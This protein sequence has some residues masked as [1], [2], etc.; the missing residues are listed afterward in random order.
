MAAGI[1]VHLEGDKTREFPGADGAERVVDTLNRWS[2]SVGALAVLKGPELQKV[3]KSTEWR[4]YERHLDV[5]PQPLQHVM[6]PRRDGEVTPIPGN[7]WQLVESVGDRRGPYHSWVIYR[8]KD[9]RA[10]FRH[11]EVTLDRE[12][13]LQEPG[14]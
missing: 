6:V 4:W 12:P 8:D 10:V 2:L 14:P 9:T 11:V 5:E 7:R 1:T 3:F 13:W